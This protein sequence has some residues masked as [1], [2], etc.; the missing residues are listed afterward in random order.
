MRDYLNPD[1]AEYFF[2]LIITA[3]WQLAALAAVALIAC[4][5]ARRAWLRAAIWSGCIVGMF[6]VP[7]VSVLLPHCYLAYGSHY[8]PLHFP[9]H[10]AQPAANHGDNFWGLSGAGWWGG[11]RRALLIVWAIG[12]AVAM[13]RMIGGWF[14]MIRLMRLARPCNDARVQW[15]LKKAV[16]RPDR[17]IVLEL[18]GLVGAICWQLHRA[19][20]I[21]PA[22]AQQLSNNELEMMIRHEWSHL[23]RGDPGMVF[24]QRIAEVLYWFHPALWMASVQASKYREFA[25]DDIVLAAGHR[26][27]D[28]AGCLGKLALWFY[29]PTPLAPAGLGLVWNQHVVLQ[30]VKRILQ[31]NQVTCSGSWRSHCMVF[32]LS[33]LIM[34][35]IAL[36]RV[37]LTERLGTGVQCTAW[38]RWTAGVLDL[39]GI[40]LRDFPLD[41]HIYDDDSVERKRTNGGLQSLV[42]S[43]TP[44]VICKTL[45][46]AEL[47]CR[48][49]A[50]AG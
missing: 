40:K 5:F 44:A 11:V 10:I 6:A 47:V 13:L 7:L 25:C 28:Y 15:I 9:T 17:V 41:A 45:G 26:A 42:G 24:V 38:P 4:V 31:N 21:M 22:N 1:W 39:F 30:R 35:L 50:H 3:T 43:H 23:H 27:R 33:A 18:E 14:G 48:S 37:D 34:F 8:E 49:A 46:Q 29:S 2:G 32:S 12:A 16:S 19:V 36:I 20:M